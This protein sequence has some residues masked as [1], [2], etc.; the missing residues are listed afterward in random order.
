MCL[1]FKHPFAE[2]LGVSREAGDASGT[3]LGEILS[4]VLPQSN[5]SD[6]KK[7]KS[8]ESSVSVFNVAACASIQGKY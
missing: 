6:I 2:E 3:N 1:K 8:S 5:M 4:N 7:E